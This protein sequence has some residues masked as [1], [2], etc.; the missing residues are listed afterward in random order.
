MYDEFLKTLLCHLNNA[1]PKKFI[2]QKKHKSNWVTEELKKEKQ[3]LRNTYDLAR[4]TNCNEL[5]QKYKT[6]KK[7]YRNNLNTAKIK[8]NGNRIEESTNPSKTVWNIVNS[9]LDRGKQHRPIILSVDGQEKNTKGRLPTN[10]DISFRQLLRKR[11][12]IILA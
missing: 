5:M 11:L 3:T 2:I 7:T 9:E 4:Q 12:N 6:M 1:C 10:L 8:Y